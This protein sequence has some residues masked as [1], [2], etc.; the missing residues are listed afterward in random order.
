MRAK[1]AVA[2]LLVAVGISPPSWGHE[3]KIASASGLLA[4]CTYQSG[5]R[6]EVEYHTGF[7][8]GFLKAVMNMHP[9]HGKTFCIPESL[10][11]GGLMR[12]IRDA[13]YRLPT[14]YMSAPSHMVVGATFEAAF[15]CSPQ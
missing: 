15:P 2:W 8:L 4:N 11:N 13:L 12:V 6:A 10:D 7:C 5:D 3:I 1:L 9:T 14:E